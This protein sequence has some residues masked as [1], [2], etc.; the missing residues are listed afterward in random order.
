MPPFDAIDFARHIQ[1]RGRQRRYNEAQARE[2]IENPDRIIKTAQRGQRGGL[3]WKFR[4]SFGGR[5][6]Q[7]V[8][9]IYQ[10]RCYVITG[11]WLND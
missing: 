10:N 8:A 1:D 5:T 11:Y 6:L 4:K 2:C 3:I 9:E 7:I